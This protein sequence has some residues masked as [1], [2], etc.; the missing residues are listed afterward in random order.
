MNQL[1]LSAV[2]SSIGLYPRAE[3]LEQIQNGLIQ[4]SK[5]ING[6]LF[7]APA[8]DVANI[9][10]IWGCV[11]ANLGGG[12]YSCTEGAFYYNGEI[13]PVATVASVAVTGVAYKFGITT[14]YG[15]A[16]GLTDGTT[17]NDLVNKVGVFYGTTTPSNTTNI[18]INGSFRTLVRITDLVTLSTSVTNLLAATADSGWIS[19]P[20]TNS[21][22][23]VSAKYRKIKN[24]VDLRGIVDTTAMSSSWDTGAFA[25]LPAGYRPVQ[26]VYVSFLAATA[27]PNGSAYGQGVLRIQTDGTIRVPGFGVL[28]GSLQLLGTLDNITFDIA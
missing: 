25:T 18:F 17:T 4:L 16:G 12:N 15:T 11:V 13:Y 9:Y 19:L 3:E 20:M 7:N 6:G 28:S 10:I 22:T 5:A 21:C 26:D 1:D 27:F 8:S 2:T 24:T 23:N 14:T